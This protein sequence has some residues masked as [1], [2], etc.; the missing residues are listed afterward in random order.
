MTLSVFYT[1]VEM[2]ANSTIKQQKVTK[3][4]DL[5]FNLPIVLVFSN[6]VI[7]IT[8]ANWVNVIT[9]LGHLKSFFI[10]CA[11]TFE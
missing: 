1:V 7:V 3:T 10:V 5:D 4:T 9:I 6:W 8:L 11:L 2:K